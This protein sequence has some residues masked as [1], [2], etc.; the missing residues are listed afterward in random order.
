MKKTLGIL[1]IV[2]AIFLMPIA[3][4]ANSAP[5]PHPD[6]FSGNLENYEGKWIINGK[7]E[8]D[9]NW[10]LEIYY[11]EYFLYN[12]Y[13]EFSGDV[14]FTPGFKDFDMP[15]TLV[16]DFDPELGVEIIL[17]NMAGGLIDVS[18]QGLVFV[19]PGNYI[20]F[21]LDEEY[22]NY[23]KKDMIGDW[24]FDK[25]YVFVMD[26]D[27]SMVLT[28]EDVMAGS[29]T[30]DKRLILSFEKGILYQVS[31]E[32]EIRVPITHYRNRG[33]R[34]M[35]F[36]NPKPLSPYVNKFDAYIVRGSNDLA[37]KGQLVISAYP[38]PEEME[39]TILYMTFNRLTAED[40][41]E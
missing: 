32:L 23:S 37:N 40:L 12:D 21:D 9:T 25:M 26:Y 14:I 2:L 1:I 38:M 19:R 13:Q 11:G 7:T 36:E 27:F 3:A 6:P 33:W 16:L 28:N 18:G 8:E 5:Q 22:Q 39:N 20:E 24:L 30:G 4:L 15:D 29:V 31:E 34:G 17:E 10:T 41:K 35:Y